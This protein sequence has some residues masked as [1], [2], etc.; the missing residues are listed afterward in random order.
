MVGTPHTPAEGCRPLHSRFV[1]SGFPREWQVRDEESRDLT[2]AG[3]AGILEEQMQKRLTRVERK[4]YGMRLPT[5]IRSR[6]E[7]RNGAA[8]PE[9]LRE[10]PAEENFSALYGKRP[11]HIRTERVAS[12]GGISR[13]GWLVPMQHTNHKKSGHIQSSITEL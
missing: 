4:Q 1:R 2:F 12:G 9:R 5:A 6:V 8:L 13:S 7:V 10:R 11:E 3:S